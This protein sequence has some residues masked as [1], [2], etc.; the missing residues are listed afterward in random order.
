MPVTIHAMRRS[1]LPEN[2][3]VA[4]GRIRVSLPGP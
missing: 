3:V 2:G 4:G 1:A